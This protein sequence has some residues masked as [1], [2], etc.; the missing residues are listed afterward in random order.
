MTL[1]PISE[2]ILTSQMEYN[3]YG[4]TEYIYVAFYYSLCLRVEATAAP[5]ETLSVLE[6]PPP[7][8]GYIKLARGTFKTGF[9]AVVS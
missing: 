6:F 1:G 9:T 2:V 8:V 3:S 5:M 4:I 7:F